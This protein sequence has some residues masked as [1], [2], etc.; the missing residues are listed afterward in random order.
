MILT[1]F[2]GMELYPLRGELQTGARVPTD[3]DIL[4]RALVQ[5]NMPPLDAPLMWTLSMSTQNLE[6]MS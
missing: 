6:L 5:R 2:S 4:D 3:P 1:G